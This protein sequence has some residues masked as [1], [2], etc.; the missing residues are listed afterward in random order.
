M[1]MST[2]IAF[3]LFGLVQGP[4]LQGSWWE[5]TDPSR[6]PQ[7]SAGCLMARSDLSSGTV[8]WVIP[9]ISTACARAR[10]FLGTLPLRNKTCVDA[11]LFQFQRDYSDTVRL[12]RGFDVRSRPVIFGHGALGT[13]LFA[14]VEGIE[15]QRFV[16]QLG[17]EVF[18]MQSDACFGSDLPP[19][20]R[21][22]LS[23]HFELGGQSTPG[24]AGMRTPAAVVQLRAA[25]GG[26]SRI[27]LSDL[28]ARD[29]RRWESAAAGGE[30]A[31]AAAIESWALVEFLLSGASGNW[32]RCFQ[33]MLRLLASG[34]NGDTAFNDA[35][36]TGE[37]VAQALDADW[38]KW[39]TALA[40]DP[41]AET[42]DRLE[43]LAAGLRELARRGETVV[44]FER[45]HQRLGE[46]DFRHRVE[47]G[48]SGRELAAADQA[49]FKPAGGS[50]SFEL[51][52]PRKPLT[53]RRSGDAP[54]APPALR[55]H[56]TQPEL[57]IEWVSAPEEGQWT[58]LLRASRE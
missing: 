17:A 21:A 25:L 38:Q 54:Q 13:G 52:P 31:S 48:P 41:A 24:T 37:T 8:Q 1:H 19:W 14:C 9:A 53:R 5:R 6:A 49:N 36:G 46:I 35:F 7:L 23:A 16:E 22:G 45:L 15:A 32:G 58:W 33:Q 12:R 51:V 55:T 26:Q 42:A 43:F 44:E 28:L 39:C 57:S 30:D 18:A 34:A 4:P 11:D 40:P 56:D 3:G 47:R 50:G 10:G 29:R 20:A 2:V 27:A